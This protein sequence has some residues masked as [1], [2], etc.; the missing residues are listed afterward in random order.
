M[1]FFVRSHSK[2]DLTNVII[3]MRHN[4][5]FDP[6]VIF[7]PPILTIA[8]SSLLSAYTT[9]YKRIPPTL[10]PTQDEDIT[11]RSQETDENDQVE[12]AK[13]LAGAK[14]VRFQ[15]WSLSRSS[16]LYLSSLCLC[17]PV[18]AAPVQPLGNTAVSSTSRVNPMKSES[19]PTVLILTNVL[20]VMVAVFACTILTVAARYC[21]QTW[22]L[23]A[24]VMGTSSV[25]F[26]I[27]KDGDTSESELLS[28][29]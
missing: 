9:R 18:L 14:S 26:A 27:L 12:V 16:I 13:Q 11:A 19:K 20:K 4:V 5:Y 15:L 1:V 25:A 10:P 21:R 24:P 29:M 17:P 22:K 28:M 2:A 6:Y 8:I 23:L 3:D 7:G